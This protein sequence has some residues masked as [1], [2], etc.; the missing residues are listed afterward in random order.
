MQPLR[1]IEQNSHGLGNSEGSF[2]SYG[3]HGERAGMFIMNKWTDSGCF[4]GK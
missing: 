4:Q 3:Q 2:T 1:L